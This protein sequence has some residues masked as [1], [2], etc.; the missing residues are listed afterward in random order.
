M[1]ECCRRN[2]NCECE[3]IPSEV[4]DGWI[5]LLNQRYPDVLFIERQGWLLLRLT[6][7][8]EEEVL[9]CRIISRVRSQPAEEIDAKS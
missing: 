6:D 5:A 9:V 4:I 3:K 8:T 1:T 7:E 2:G